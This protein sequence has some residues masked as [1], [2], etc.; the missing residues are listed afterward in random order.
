MTGFKAKVESIAVAAN[1]TRLF[2]GTTDGVLTMFEARGD[3]PHAVRSGNIE[4]VQ[5]SQLLG[6]RST[7]NRKPVSNL[8]VVDEWR[9]LLCVAET[10][11]TVVRH[12]CHLL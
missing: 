5:I 12:F 2:A 6:A 1:G 9:A 7:A 8:V 11:L 3:T 10:C 4:L